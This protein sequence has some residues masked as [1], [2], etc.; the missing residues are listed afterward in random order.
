M[1]KKSLLI[2]TMAASVCAALPARAQL[3]QPDPSQVG[4]YP[5]PDGSAKAL[6]QQNCTICHDL[7]N[8]VNSN[9]SRD[10]WEN[11]ADMMNNAGAPISPEQ[12]GQI[13]SY[14]LPRF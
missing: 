2:L 3:V 12:P 1:S 14:L 11:T 10:D 13:N 4:N 8:V 5:L 9:K 7:R 6:V